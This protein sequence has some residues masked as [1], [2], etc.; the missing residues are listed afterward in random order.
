MV[1]I[2]IRY[3]HDVKFVSAHLVLSVYLVLAHLP[4]SM[5]LNRDDDFCGPHNWFAVHR[6][7]A[8]CMIEGC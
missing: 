4:V 3:C 1:K 7:A 6:V 8:F 5:F 2:C